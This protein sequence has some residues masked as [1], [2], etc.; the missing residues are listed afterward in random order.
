MQGCP[1]NAERRIDHRPSGPA[2]FFRGE[3][4]Y[5]YGDVMILVC[6]RGCPDVEITIGDNREEDV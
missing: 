4:D 5:Q 6:P 3:A 1:H 2:N